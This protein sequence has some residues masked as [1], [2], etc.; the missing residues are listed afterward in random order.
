MIKWVIIIV[1][2]IISYIF[3]KPDL[4]RS[5]INKIDTIKKKLKSIKGSNKQLKEK[6]YTNLY[7]L[8]YNGVHD[9]YDLKGNKIKGVTPDPEKALFYLRQAIECSNNPKLWILMAS[10]YQN[11]MYNLDPDPKMASDLY[12]YVY[13]IFPGTKESIYAT[14]QYYNAQKQLSE[15]KTYNWLGLKYKFKNNHHDKI[16]KLFTT[17]A[18]ATTATVARATPP[19]NVTRANYFRATEDEQF[20]IDDP[21]RNDMHNTHNSQVVSTVANSVKKLSQ[22]TKINIPVSETLKQIRNYIYTKPN[23]DRRNDALKSLE[24]IE[25]NILAISSVKMKEV[26][27]LNIVWNSINSDK[28]SKN[29]DDIKDILYTQLSEMQEHGKSVCPTGRLERIVDTLNTFDED[30]S[31]KPTYII[32]QEMM[33]KAA[34]IRNKMFEKI[35]KEKGETLVNQYQMGT[36]PDQNIFDDSLKKEILDKLR[37]DYVNSNIITENKFDSMTSKWIDEI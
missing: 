4:Q 9:K 33:N 29:R 27:V 14:D 7:E 21:R 6:Y 37:N 17:A 20:D 12:Q 28:H 26:D 24:S 5:Y 8:Y 13:N 34:L 10:I 36:A 2:C 35:K 25:R 30:V 19:T 16:K 22:N 1:I 18:I 15:L 23:S 32:N 31:I 11:G 3:I